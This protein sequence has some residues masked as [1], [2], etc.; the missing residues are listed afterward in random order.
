MTAC[1]TRPS[2]FAQC[3]RPGRTSLER[4][5]GRRCWRL[6]EHGVCTASTLLS[7][8]SQNHR[9]ANWLGE[10]AGG[11]FPVGL[12]GT[13][14]PGDRRLENE[15]YDVTGSGGQWKKL[16]RRGVPPLSFRPPHARE[17]ASARAGGGGTLQ[18]GGAHE[19]RSSSPRPIYKGLA[20]GLGGAISRWS[21]AVSRTAW[22]ILPTGT[23]PSRRRGPPLQ[24]TSIHLEMAFVSAYGRSQRTVQTL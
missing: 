2:L 18:P 6:G 19:R 20:P 13:L 5:A 22:R 23:E 10:M 11:R 15:D 4:K 24:S 16:P 8:E 12:C 21:G 17:R 1:R 3:S 7:P 14:L 9:A